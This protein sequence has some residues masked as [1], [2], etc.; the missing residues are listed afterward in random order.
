MNFKASDALF[1]AV[2]AVLG[3]VTAVFAYRKRRSPLAWFII[4]ML[5]PLL[6]LAWVAKLRLADGTPDWLTFKALL[7]LSPMAA[8]WIFLLLG[9][10]STVSSDYWNVAPWL[11]V[12]S[13]PVCVILAVIVKVLSAMASTHDRQMLQAAAKAAPQKPPTRP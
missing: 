12:A 3:F 5:A 2:W 1:L 13:L 8:A 6:A 9:S 10:L 4:G 11:V 7:V